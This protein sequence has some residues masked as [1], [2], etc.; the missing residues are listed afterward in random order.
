MKGFTYIVRLKGV[1]LPKAWYYGR[2]TPMIEINAFSIIM[3]GSLIGVSIVGIW[4]SIPDIKECMNIIK[5]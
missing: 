5:N 4:A 2:L 1:T 3:I